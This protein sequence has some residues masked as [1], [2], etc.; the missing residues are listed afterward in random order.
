MAEAGW[1][2]VRGH[3]GG[4]AVF[5]TLALNH[6]G[7]VVF[8][9]RLGREF[10]KPQ[11]YRYFLTFL[12]VEKDDPS[13]S[14]RDFT[15]F[16]LFSCL[17]DDITAVFIEIHDRNLKNQYLT[18]AN[19]GSILNGGV[20]D[21]DP[22]ALHI[23]FRIPHRL[24]KPDPGFGHQRQQG[25][26]IKMVPIVDMTDIDSHLG[27]KSKEFRQINLYAGHGLFFRIG[28]N[29]PGQIINRNDHE[30]HRGL[31]AGNSEDIAIG[32]NVSQSGH[33]QQGNHR[34]EAV[35]GSGV[36]RRQQRAGISIYEYA[37]EQ[38]S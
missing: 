37:T 10:F 8:H 2:A 12:V 9:R 1:I 25:R 31:N 21:N 32:L 34:A 19:F 17:P 33:R 16:D 38:V 36:D 30:H 3:L 18:M 27:G 28:S 13:F 15:A 20:G 26:I 7:I 24:E 14:A 29:Q 5:I 6:R 35:F 23:Q 11:W 22:G 4:G